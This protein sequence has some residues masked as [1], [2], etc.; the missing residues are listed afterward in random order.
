MKR[1]VLSLGAFCV[2]VFCVLSFASTSAQGAGSTAG[3][4]IDKPSGKSSGNESMYSKKG[5][6]AGDDSTKKCS[7]PKW[8][9]TSTD[10][11]MTVCCDADEAC[12]NIGNGSV[13]CVPKPT[14]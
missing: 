5:T 13:A 2:G 11:S 14:K 3:A 9:C 1:H 6:W 4:A 7:S 12:Q 8:T 10:G